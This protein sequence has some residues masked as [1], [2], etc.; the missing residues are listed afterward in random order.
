MVLL[1]MM[2]Q[3]E[4]IMPITKPQILKMAVHVLQCRIESN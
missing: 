4:K 3:K 2:A 1:K